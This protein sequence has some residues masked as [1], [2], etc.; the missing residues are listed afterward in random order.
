[1]NYRKL[2]SN[3]LFDE[4]SQRFYLHEDDVDHVTSDCIGVKTRDAIVPVAHH[5]DHHLITS[6]FVYNESLIA[7]QMPGEDGQTDD[8][9]CLLR[10]D[11]P[12]DIQL[13]AESGLLEIRRN[14]YATVSTSHDSRFISIKNIAHPIGIIL[15]LEKFGTIFAY[16][17]V[18]NKD[19]CITYDGEFF[20]FSG[21]K[22]KVVN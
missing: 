12:T 22:M 1:M 6:R 9:L 19:Y 17:T 21:E 4:H 2:F 11:K 5:A 20:F 18:D 7:D 16:G 14:E 13:N 10:I 8:S 3:W 15:R